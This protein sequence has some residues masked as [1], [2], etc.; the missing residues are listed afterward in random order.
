M[1]DKTHGY[2]NDFYRQVYRNLN[3]SRSPA[4]VSRLKPLFILESRLS[5]SIF[6]VSSYYLKYIAFITDVNS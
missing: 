6:L 3:D 4:P 1:Q 2:E 5:S